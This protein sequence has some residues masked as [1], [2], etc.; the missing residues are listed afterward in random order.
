VTDALQINELCKYRLRQADEAISEAILLKDAGFFRGA[1]NRA[2]YSM[3]Y[4]VQVLIVLNKM[5]ISKHS[6]AISFF[7]REFVK[8]GTID[9]KFSKWLHKLFDLRQDADYGDMFEPSEDH[10]QQAVE[11]ARQFVQRIR[12][13]FES[14]IV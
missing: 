14:T 2:Y 9:K 4:G 8:S 1:I 11:Q 13:H 5:K 6:G 12:E 10:C 7:D 3:F